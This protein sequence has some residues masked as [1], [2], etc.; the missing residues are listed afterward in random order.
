M[1]VY[2]W[3]EIASDFTDGLVLGNGASIAFDR[4]FN[5]ASLLQKGKDEDL[6]NQDVRLVFK[7]LKTVDF[8]LVLRMLWHASKINEALSL[9]DPR[10]PAAYA[11]VREAL[12]KV[13]RSIHVEYGQVVDRLSLVANFMRQFE[14]V[15]SLNY[16]V[17]VYWAILCGN[18]RS[19][20]H[21]FKDCFVDDGHFRQ[22]WKELRDP[23]P[24]KT[25]TTIVGYPHLL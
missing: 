7:H 5:Y 15:A 13:V 12:I 16:D 2:Q 1:T 10:T 24:P 14:T 25:D 9:E 8:E 11:N 23:M 6:I 22:S 21:M 18:K 19:G 17:L 4:R 20:T 3:L